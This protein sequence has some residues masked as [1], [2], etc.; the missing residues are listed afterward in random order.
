LFTSLW[1]LPPAVRKKVK[2]AA[3]RSTGRRR[4]RNRD[5]DLRYGVH[6]TR[7]ASGSF[8]DLGGHGF[9]I[10]GVERSNFDALE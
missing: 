3:S 5:G 4:W 6:S 10:R 7:L 9:R 8:A 1:T 2:A